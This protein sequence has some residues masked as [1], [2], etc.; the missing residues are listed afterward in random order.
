MKLNLL[1][2]SISLAIIMVM[3][4]IRKDSNAKILYEINL[5]LNKD[6]KF[7]TGDTNVIDI[8]NDL[9]KRKSYGNLTEIQSKYLISIGRR[10]AYTSKYMRTEY[11]MY[12]LKANIENKD[13]IKYMDK[14][15]TEKLKS[16]LSEKDRMLV[17]FDM[18]YFGREIKNEK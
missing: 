13:V 5:E 18:H 2:M 15:D 3:V 9:L 16:M 17:R 10:A 4:I 12:R 8:E 6:V 1:A 14:V 11:K 7:I